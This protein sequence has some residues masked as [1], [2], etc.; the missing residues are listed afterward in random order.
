MLEIKAIVFVIVSPSFDSGI[1]VLFRKIQLR[2][3]NWTLKFTENLCVA[4]M[5]VKLVFKMTFFAID[6]RSI[7]D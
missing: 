6:G 5:F 2:F 1:N 3:L 4:A 7:F